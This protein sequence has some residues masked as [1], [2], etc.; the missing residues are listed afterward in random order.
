METPATE[1][2]KTAI[3]NSVSWY[4]ADKLRD[5][6]VSIAIKKY[7]TSNNLL[8]YLT[9]CNV[10]ETSVPRIKVQIL[11]RVAGGIHE[12]SYQLYNDHRLEK[13]QNDMIFGIDKVN[14]GSQHETVSEA[15]AHQLLDLVNSLQNARQTL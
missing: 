14:D 2:V 15:E 1:E 13:T 11:Q 3:E 12:S 9:R 10:A 7:L 6:T 4:L 5:A 8:V